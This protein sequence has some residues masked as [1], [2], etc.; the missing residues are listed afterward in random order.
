[1]SE[2]TESA[3]EETAKDATQDEAG[4]APPVDP[5]N[6]PV[7][8]RYEMTFGF[9]IALFAAVLALNELAAGKYGDDELQLNTE[10][11]S[12]YLWY[13][14]KGIKSTLVEGQR[15]LLRAL[16]EGGAVGGDKAPVLQKQAAALDQRIA[17]YEKE[18]DEIL[19]GSEAVGKDNWR[20][21]VDGELGKVVGV[22]SI[23]G[24]LERLGRAGDRFDL[25][26]LFLQLGLVLGA[27]GILMSQEKM[28]RLFLGGLAAMGIAG[29]VCSSLALHMAGLF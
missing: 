20:Q 15:D 5:D 21:E 1:M 9:V 2:A 29:T 17:R 16:V 6:D 4:A 24:K 25:A 10:K 11:T 27:I 28:K 22:K 13:Q 7:K 23:E 18:K 26:T 8:K 12:A 19:R 14:S 3:K